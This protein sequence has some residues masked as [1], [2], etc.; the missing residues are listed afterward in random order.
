MQRVDV[1]RPLG[2]RELLL[3]PR[4]LE[5]D[6]G[7]ERRLR[8]SCHAV[9]I[10]GGGSLL[11]RVAAAATTSATSAA[12][13]CRE[14][15]HAEEHRRVAPEQVGEEPPQRLGVREAPAAALEEDVWKP[16]RNQSSSTSSSTPTKREEPERRPRARTQRAPRDVARPPHGREHDQR[17]EAT[18]VQRR[19]GSR[20]AGARR[21]CAAS[22]GR[23]RRACRRRSR[24]RRSRSIPSRCHGRIESSPTSASR[25]ALGRL[26]AERVVGEARPRVLGADEPPVRQQVEAVADEQRR[27]EHR[28]HHD[29]GP[30]RDD[31]PC[32]RRIIAR[33]GA[34]QRLTANSTVALL[35]V[36]GNL[37]DVQLGRAVVDA[38][39]AG[40]GLAA[41]RDLLLR[42]HHGSGSCSTPGRSCRPPSG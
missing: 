15:E 37:H 17:D 21:A 20:A 3:R 10:R 1:L 26:H 2:L 35:P 34:G 41:A 22:P 23:R 7:V 32:H 6:L 24:A 12:S 30:G 11:P 18:R 25:V 31:S 42:E 27:R 29:G 9:F 16:V 36:F 28:E 38:H 19:A 5:V 40:E 4:E 33:R 14:R 13:A 8:P 39:L